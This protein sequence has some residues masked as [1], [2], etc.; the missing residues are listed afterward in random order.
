MKRQTR[1]IRISRETL[2]R[3]DLGELSRINGGIDWT[4][5]MS[6]CTQCTFQAVATDAKPPQQELDVATA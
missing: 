6:E 5:C 4:G 1:K 2:R 3:L